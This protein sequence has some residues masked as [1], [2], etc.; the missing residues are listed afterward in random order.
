[1]PWNKGQKY[2]VQW[3]RDACDLCMWCGYKITRLMLDHFLFKKLHNRNVV[4]LSLLPSPIPTPLHV[5]L[6]LLEAMLQVIFWLFVSSFAFAFTASTDSNL[7][8]FNTHLIFGNKKKSH[9]ARSGE[10]GGCSNMEILC[11]I[12]NILTD[13]A[14]F[15]STQSWWRTHEPFFQISGLL[16]T[17]S[18]RFVKTSL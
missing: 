13:R 15:A 16:L 7:V 12:K 6:P 4:T 14:L 3:Q 1:M 9:G 10:Y 18:R 2:K 17:R 11:F 8:P 5:N